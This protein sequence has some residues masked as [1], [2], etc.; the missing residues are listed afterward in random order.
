MRDVFKP[1][2]HRCFPNVTVSCTLLHI[3][4]QRSVFSFAT[5]AMQSLLRF[6]I[7]FCTSAC[8]SK[9]GKLVDSRSLNRKNYQVRRQRTKNLR[10]KTS[11]LYIIFIICTKMTSSS[12]VSTP[13][14][15]YVSFHNIYFIHK[16]RI[17]DV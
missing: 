5:Y 16:A 6:R 7:N 9:Y 10:L 2:S 11:Y 12:Y 13:Y 14:V 3:S 17:L 15:S 1:L 8:R 4:I